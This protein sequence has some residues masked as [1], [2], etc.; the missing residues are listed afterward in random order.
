MS[1]FF[2]LGFPCL[3]ADGIIRVDRPRLRIPKSF[4]QLQ[5]LNGLLKKYRDIYPYRIVVCY[6]ITY[7]LFVRFTFTLT[8]C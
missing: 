2:S 4:A 7:L 3:A 8:Q 6:V 5:D 1:K